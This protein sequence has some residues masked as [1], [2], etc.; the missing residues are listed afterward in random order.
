MDLSEIVEP[1]NEFYLDSKRLLMKC[2]KPD[3]KGMDDGSGA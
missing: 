3:A 1:M 2:S